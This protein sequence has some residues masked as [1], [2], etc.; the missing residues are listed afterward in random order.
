MF[1]MSPGTLYKLFYLVSPENLMKLVAQGHTAR[2][3]QDWNPV[4]CMFLANSVTSLPWLF[5]PLRIN[6]H[7]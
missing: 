3:S 5:S 7:Q 2:E 4:G 6:D 1:Q